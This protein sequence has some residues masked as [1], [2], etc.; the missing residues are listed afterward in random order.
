MYRYRIFCGCVLSWILLAG[1]SESLADSN[2]RI[3]FG[4]VDITPSE[5]VRLSGYASRKESSAGVADL[6]HARAMVVSS[7]DSDDAVGETI[8]LVSFD[9][10]GTTA[11][12]TN[13]IA[14]WLLSQYQIPRRC[15]AISSTHSHASPHLQTGLSNLYTE[16]STESQTAATVAYTRQVVEGIKK[17]VQA[18]MS[19]RRSGSLLI[20]E[21]KAT[22]AVNRRLLKNGTWSGFGVQ[23]DGQIDHRVRVM[24]A[25]SSNGELMGCF[26]LYACHCTTL[27]GDFNQ[28]SG[29]WAG[30]SA[31]RLESLFPGTVC[32]PIIGCGADQN[33]NPRGTYELA[34]QHAMEM[35][36]SVDRVLKMK[37][38]EKIE[39]L[40]IARFGYAGLAPEQPSDDQLKKMS[41]SSKPNERRWAAEMERI[42]REMGRLPETYPMPIHTWQFGDLLTCVFLGGEVVVD[43]Q[44]RLEK[45][46]PTKQTWVAAYTDDVFAYVASEKMRAEN[47][48]EVDFSM[49]YYLQ[50]GRWQSG[51]QSLII[52]RTAEILRNQSTES[53]PLS[54]AESLK[55]I[56]VPEGF[57]VEL[58]ASEPLVQDPINVA[59]DPD[60]SVWVVEMCDYPQG[61][62]GGG[63]VKRLRDTSG[64]GVLNESTVFLDGLRYPTSVHPWRD[65]VVVI[66]APEV[67]FAADRDGDGKAEF[68]ET[69]LTGLAE[70]NPQHRA[71]GFEIGLDGRL[72]FG[73]GSETK[74]VHSAKNGQS[75]NVKHRDAVWNPDT[76][77]IEATTGETQFVR[78]RDTFGQWFGNSNS[79]PM[80]H[81]VIEDRYLQ[82]DSV[83][84][85]PRRPLLDPPVAP[86]VY[87]RSMTIDR[88]NDLHTLNRYTSACSSIVARVP[89]V[90]SNNETIAFVCEP[91][92]NLVA[93]LRMK[94]DGSTFSAERHPDDKEFDFFTSTDPM[95]RP[96]RVVNAPDGTIWIVDMVRKVIEHPQWIPM[97]WQQKIDLREGANLGRIYRVYR[98]DFVPTKLPKIAA[99]K[100][101]I[102]KAMQ[103]DNGAL[104]D[105]AL[106]RLMEDRDD[107]VQED[108]RKLS[109][110][111]LDPA[112]RASALGSLAARKWLNSEDLV[113]AF[114]DSD[115]RLVRYALEICEPFLEDKQLRRAFFDLPRRELGACV[116]LQW[117]LTATGIGDADSFTGWETIIRRSKGNLWIG[118]ALSLIREPKLIRRIIPLVTDEW[119]RF[120]DGESSIDFSELVKL[121]TPLWQRLSNDE[122]ADIVRTKLVSKEG[123]DF[124]PSHLLYLALLSRTSKP[125]R[126]DEGFGKIVQHARERMMNVDASLQE[127]ET[128]IGLIGTGCFD[129]KTELSDAAKLLQSDQPASIK[130]SVLDALV[131]VRA[132]QVAPVVIDNWNHLSS[133]LKSFACSI[134]M[135]RTVSGRDLVG[136]LERIHIQS[137]DL[138]PAVVQRLISQSDRGL[139][140]RCI[141][142]F[143]TPT[144]RDQVVARYVAEIPSPTLDASGQELYR[145]NCAACHEAKQNQP[146]LGPPLDNLRHWTIEQ[147]VTA[148][149]HPNRNVE[150]K[151]AQ[152]IVVTDSDATAQGLVI[153]KTA[154]TLRLAQA[155]GAIREIPIAEIVDIKSTSLSLMPEGFEAR[156]TPS[157]LAY[158]IAYCRS[159]KASLPNGVPK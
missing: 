154:Q 143:G 69:W 123:I 151:Y 92:H 141:A 6:L 153:E 132:D 41:Q 150:A 42:R 110:E 135:T 16:P 56:R 99:Q 159:G 148:V 129:E 128:L 64:D 8:I 2:L 134:L 48:Y 53:E 21:D 133:S 158:V 25:E 72:H 70:A 127:R 7:S 90:V 124:E 20:G 113:I 145:A 52:Q 38:L 23:A 78:S 14:G 10:I 30:L 44:F 152:S 79:Q 100:V 67:V 45:E 144:P 40:P 18:A 39:D 93:R 83:F 58:V 46:L 49:I 102:V 11:A 117:I 142:L 88:F 106:L 157:Q 13:E 82:G 119:P 76:G 126:G 98:N 155:D 101:E 31:C 22:F 107:S 61:V 122:R 95:S 140:A 71:A 33:P 1:Y 105:L 29:D 146:A 54:A 65:G 66:A 55:S 91:V 17:A 59:F 47:G 97:S 26:Y 86:P 121:V 4:K 50:P 15:V 94:Q 96:V 68:R 51:T 57:R 118:K 36:D 136:F 81:Y 130:R 5:S 115:G 147:W 77:E 114:Q 80:F 84:G 125:F 60:G 116:D 111:H 34:Q 9:G 75:Y 149:M 32:L 112:V 131:N 108:I 73:V 156:L 35:V 89:G 104:R 43:Y 62:E 3:G 103:S 28:V 63:R 109:R 137:S 24:R 74:I 27:G 138:E 85:G 87:P 37:E 12:I 139:R 120:V 19:A